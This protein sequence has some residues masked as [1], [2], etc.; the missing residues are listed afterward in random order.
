MAG[1]MRNLSVYQRFATIIAALTIVLLAVSALQIPVLRDAVLDQRRTTVRDLVE[2]ATT[3]LGHY[4]GEAAAPLTSQSEQLK[5]K[6][7]KFLGSIRTA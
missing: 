3:V 7:G 4:E 5:T 1:G 6:T 2:A